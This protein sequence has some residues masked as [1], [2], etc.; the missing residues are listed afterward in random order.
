MYL[1]NTLFILYLLKYIVWVY[2]CCPGIKYIIQL[3]FNPKYFGNC[4][5]N[6]QL[7]DWLRFLRFYKDN[8]FIS[9]EI[10][11]QY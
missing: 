4:S 10:L 2:V 11:A 3:I 7:L 5:F 6:K 1:C 9:Y 8:C